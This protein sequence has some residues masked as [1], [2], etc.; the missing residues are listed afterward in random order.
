MEF[1][2]E[3]AT[4]LVKQ[5]VSFAVGNP[6]RAMQDLLFMEEFE[7]A[8]L[9]AI[10]QLIFNEYDLDRETLE[11]LTELQKSEELPITIE[12]ELKRLLSLA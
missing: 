1:S 6:L 7:L 4:R 10:E 9:T 5:A 12:N 8:A 3:L 2:E 11:A